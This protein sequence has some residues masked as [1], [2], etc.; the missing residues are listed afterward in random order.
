MARL[1]LDDLRAGMVLAA[2][3]TDLSGRVL[4]RAGTALADNH[5]RMFRMWGLGVADV[6]GDEPA[7]SATDA[8]AQIDPI[9]RDAV[10][11]RVRERFRHND[12]DDAVI[13]QLMRWCEQDALAEPGP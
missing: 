11:T 5:L 6:E 12:P 9:R 1:N 2:D 3:A 7:A 4:L 10:Q 13:A 8:L